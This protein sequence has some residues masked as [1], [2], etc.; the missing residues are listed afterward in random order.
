MGQAR[1]WSNYKQ[2]PKWLT[3]TQVYFLFVASARCSVG[4]GSA[5]HGHCPHSRTQG[6]NQPLSGALPV[7][8]AGERENVTGMATESPPG[9]D[10]AQCF[11]LVD[12]SRSH[13]QAYCPEG[14]DVCPSV[15][16]TDWKWTCL[17]TEILSAPNTDDQGKI[18]KLIKIYSLLSETNLTWK[19]REI[20]HSTNIYCAVIW[21]KYKWLEHNQRAH[22]TLRD[23]R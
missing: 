22:N 14:R 4:C 5:I 7:T 19:K 1:H 20:H 17:W 16:H 18:F 11:H 13:D 3:K 15:S 23:G 8:A 2:P 10:T 21:A 9:R 12:Q 6:D